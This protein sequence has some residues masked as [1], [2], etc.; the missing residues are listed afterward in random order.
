L[1][2]PIFSMQSVRGIEMGTTGN[3]DFH[4]LLFFLALRKRRAHRYIFCFLASAKGCR[5]DP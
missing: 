3:G 4:G 5:F 2:R 1:I